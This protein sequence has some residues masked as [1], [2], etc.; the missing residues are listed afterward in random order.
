MPPLFFQDFMYFLNFL[1]YYPMSAYLLAANAAAL[2]A[3]LAEQDGGGSR[4]RRF[5]LLFLRGRQQ[6]HALKIINFSLHIIRST[7][8]Y[9]TGRHLLLHSFGTDRSRLKGFFLVA[10]NFLKL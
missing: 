10:F 5:R 1:S 3:E 6:H 9:L 8:I 4:G 7:V 2:V